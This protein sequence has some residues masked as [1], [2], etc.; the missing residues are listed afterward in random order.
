[1]IRPVLR[2]VFFDVGGTLLRPYPSVGTVY[3]RV[4]ERHGFNAGADEWDRAF[5][6]GWKSAKAAE[7]RSLTTADKLWWRAL[8]FRAVDSL[9]LGG[10]DRVRHDYFEELYAA[11]ARADAWQLYPGVLEVLRAV[12][13]RGGLHLGVISNWDARLRPLLKE[14]RLDARFDSITVSCEVKA[15]KPAREIFETALR[16]AGVLPAEA[17]H[18][19]DSLEEDVRGAEAVGMRA[20]LIDRQ[21]EPKSPGAVVGDLSEI[22]AVLGQDFPKNS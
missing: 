20:I 5:R 10:N 15:E 18:V 16:V 3:A 6:A 14:L 19:G 9:G 22:A 7:G 21:G 13:V 8:V 2:A 17:L 4:G 11:F 12:R 1:V